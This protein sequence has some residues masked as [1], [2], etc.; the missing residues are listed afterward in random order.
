MHSD[1]SLNKNLIVLHSLGFFTFIL[2]LYFLV[3]K[4]PFTGIGLTSQRVRRFEVTSELPGRKILHFRSTEKHAGLPTKA[5]PRGMFIVDRDV[6]RYAS[7]FYNLFVVGQ[8]R[9]PRLLRAQRQPRNLL[10][11]WDVS[12]IPVNGIFLPKK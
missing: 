7:N 8:S 9:S 5:L 2:F 3:R 10:T 12:S 1:F 11:L 4:I 6:L